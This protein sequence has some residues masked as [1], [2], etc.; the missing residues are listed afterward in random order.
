[1]KI[2]KSQINQNMS[3]KKQTTTT[4]KKENTIPR[5]TTF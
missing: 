3:H 2:N 1:M 5:Y 4:K